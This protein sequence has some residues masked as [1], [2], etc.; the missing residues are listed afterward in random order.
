MAFAGIGVFQGELDEKGFSTDALVAAGAGAGLG[1]ATGAGAGDA[2]PELVATWHCLATPG[3]GSLPKVEDWQRWLPES[4]RSIQLEFAPKRTRWVPET[5]KFCHSSA[6]RLQPVVVAGAGAAATGAGAGAGAGAELVRTSHCLAVMGAGSPPK[7][8]A[9]Q[10]TV[11]LSVRV[12]QRVPAPK[13]TVCVP[14]TVKRCH[15]EATRV[16][17]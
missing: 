11:P 10:A 14:V 16:Q 17:L 13:R 12:A 6:I 2:V 8:E 7:V 15:S 3:A 5:L 1:E 4:D 9:W